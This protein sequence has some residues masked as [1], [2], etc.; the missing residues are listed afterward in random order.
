MIGD[1]PKAF[2]RNFAI[3]YFLPSAIYILG[4]LACLRFFGYAVSGQITK[5][6]PWFS[7][8][9]LAVFTW[10][11]GVL[12]MALNR[13]L[14]RLKEG[15][16]EY[17]P[18]L[19]WKRLERSRY[20]KLE[21]DLESVEQEWWD[22]S[23]RKQEPSDS[24]KKQRIQLF[25]KAAEEFPDS[26][27]LLMP[28]RFGNTVRAFEVYPRVMYG[29]EATSGWDRLL[30]V[31]PKE[32][33]EI[34]DGLKAQMDFWVNLWFLGIVFSIQWGVLCILNRRASW[35][36]AI[37]AVLLF[38]LWASRR[39]RYAAADWGSLIKAA[40]DTCLPKLIQCLGLA[41]GDSNEAQRSALESFSQAVTY[42]DA[43]S[44]PP[45]QPL[46]EKPRG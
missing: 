5:D 37:L 30:A 38:S 7:T 20:L 16:G 12:L 23:D 45:R 36:W 13:T 27:D 43:E 2:D 14:I 15:Y 3:G 4:C 28:T 19:L 32:M 46:K 22:C 18:A 39:S 21:S 8:S 11:G 40:C 41:V 44:L 9:L 34:I 1:L 33:Q 26:V 29:L 35:L 6:N 17:N 10:L 24:L 25:F 42:R 31:I